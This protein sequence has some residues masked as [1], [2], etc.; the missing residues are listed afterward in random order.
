MNVCVPEILFS[1]ELDVI[2]SSGYINERHDV[3]VCYSLNGE[4]L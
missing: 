4:R 2:Q 1:E 3:G